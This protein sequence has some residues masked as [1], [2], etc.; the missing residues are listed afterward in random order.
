MKLV[1]TRDFSQKADLSYALLNP[2]AGGGG[3]FSP[4]G[5]APFSEGFF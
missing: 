3:L 2:S 1:S 4:A 5:L